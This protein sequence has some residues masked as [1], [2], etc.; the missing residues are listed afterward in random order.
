M[1]VAIISHTFCNDKSSPFTTHLVGTEEH[2]T[3]QFR[4]LW[5]Y[6]HKS[7]STP[8]LSSLFFSL[9]ISISFY[10]S[11]KVWTNSQGVMDSASFLILKMELGNSNHDSFKAWRRQAITRLVGCSQGNNSFKIEGTR[12][13][14][15]P[16][17]PKSLEFPP[18]MDPEKSRPLAFRPGTW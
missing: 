6:F 17:S 1:K 16:C 10:A 15:R 2:F 4:Q 18:L 3:T 8:T 13:G 9:K 14:Y 7:L 5:S 12:V 11:H